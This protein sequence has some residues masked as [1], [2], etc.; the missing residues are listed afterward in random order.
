MPFRSMKMYFFILGFQRRGW[1]GENTPA[2]PKGLM[3]ASGGRALPLLV[4]PPPARRPPA[5]PRGGGGAGG[6][7]GPRG[8]AVDE[9]LARA[10]DEAHAGG[11]LLAAA[12]GRLRGEGRTQ[13][14]SSIVRARTAP[15]EAGRALRGETR[16][17]TG[18]TAPWALARR[19]GARCR[20]RS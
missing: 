20:C 12:G 15:G 7:A 10:G 14:V 3:V 17:S 2:P 11:G 13:A 5:A 19:A 16:L 4:L 18:A 9:R 6:P 8:P 1:G